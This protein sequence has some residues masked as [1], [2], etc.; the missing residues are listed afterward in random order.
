MVEENLTEKV[1]GPLPGTSPEYDSGEKVIRDIYDEAVGAAGSAL[2][3]AV[4]FLALPVIKWVFKFVFGKITN[5]IYGE[6]SKRLAVMVINAKVQAELKAYE[7]AESELKAMLSKEQTTPE[8]E[9][10]VTDEFKKRLSDLIRI[11]HP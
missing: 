2:I 1:E 4:P 8:E 6:L 10:R 3:S 7:R 9:K 11:P 5:L